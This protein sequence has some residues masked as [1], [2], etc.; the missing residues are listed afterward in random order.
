MSQPVN[1]SSALA[2]DMGASSFGHKEWCGKVEVVPRSTEEQRSSQAQVAESFPR[3][4]L[5]M[6]CY[7]AVTEAEFDSEYSNFASKIKPKSCW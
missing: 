2:Q 7:E 4:T 1:A 6:C 3:T 5:S